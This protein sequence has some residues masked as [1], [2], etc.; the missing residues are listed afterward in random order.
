[1]LTKFPKD[2]RYCTW[3]RHI[4]NKM[5]FYGISESKIRRVVKSPK[6]VEEGIAPDTTAVMQRNDRG[7]KREEIWVMYQTKNKRRTMNN[8]KSEKPIGSTLVA[9][10]SQKLM[11]SAWRYPGITKSG[12][13]IPIPDDVLADLAET[14]E[15]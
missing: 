1:M 12:T 10:G 8:Q 2:D 3:T 5:V 4:K 6:R 15:A 14:L 7:A 9:S 13:P 11:I